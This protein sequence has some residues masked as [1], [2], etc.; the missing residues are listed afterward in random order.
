M[1]SRL[2]LLHSF[3]AEKIKA[4]QYRDLGLLSQV[5]WGLVLEEIRTKSDLENDRCERVR[6]ALQVQPDTVIRSWEFG[7]EWVYA[8]D[9][10]MWSSFGV[11][12]TNRFQVVRK[13]QCQRYTIEVELPIGD[14]KYES[15]VRHDRLL[16]FNPSNSTWY[17]S[18]VFYDYEDWPFGIPYFNRYMRD[19]I[20]PAGVEFVRKVWESLPNGKGWESSGPASVPDWMRQWMKEKVEEERLDA[21]RE[22]SSE[23][24]K[25]RKEKQKRKETLAALNLKRKKAISSPATEMAMLHAMGAIKHT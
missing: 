8:H 15:N 19:T 24:W 12:E 18:K 2:E 10:C 6:N 7:N 22:K 5:N 4:T 23:Y 9:Y 11:V 16:A 20:E 3:L 13:T 1:Q 14:S 17:V 21:E 25:Q